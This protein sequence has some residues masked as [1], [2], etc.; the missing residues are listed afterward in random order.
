MIKHSKSDSDTVFILLV[1]FPFIILIFTVI[2]FFGSIKVLGWKGFLLFLLIFGWG[3]Y[4]STERVL[5]NREGE[6]KETNFKALMRYKYMVAAIICNVILIPT[7]DNYLDSREEYKKALEDYKNANYDEVVRHISF[8]QNWD[9]STSRLDKL[10]TNS[11]HKWIETCQKEKTEAAAESCYDDL[12]S[13]GVVDVETQRIL[14][15]ELN[16]N[17]S[18]YLLKQREKEK[19]QYAKKE[20]FVGMYSE[21]IRDTSWGT[22][23]E[24]INSNGNRGIHEYVW[25]YC[26]GGK[27]RSKSVLVVNGAVSDVDNPDVRTG[28]HHLC[29][30]P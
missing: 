21:Y 22:P 23:D 9:D 2:C 24:S 10:K 25:Y 12:Y 6:Q 15:K 18:S 3:T 11:V 26:E 13:M 30:Q 28:T 27:Q 29:T 7:L 17:K 14:K 1:F 8:L 4:K 20:P 19:S 5:E 16:F